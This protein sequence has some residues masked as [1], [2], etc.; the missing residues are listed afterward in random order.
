[1]R[2]LRSSLA[3]GVF[4]G[5]APL[6]A[7]AQTSGQPEFPQPVMVLSAGA[8]ADLS[9][10]LLQGGGK[11]P[12]VA[13]L[14]NALLLPGVGNFY[15]GNSGHG[16]RHLLLHVGG[17]GVV[18]VGAAA[19]SDEIL[20]GGTIDE[21]S[22]AVLY[23]GLGIVTVNW[24]WSIFSGISDANAAGGRSAS[25]GPRL[26]TLSVSSPTLQA[27]APAQA[28]RVGLEVVRIGF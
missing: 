14:L 20:T 4:F 5:L 3:M 19:A 2:Q 12:A 21:G 8:P 6:A 7:Q 22:V 11:S 26:R 27:L 18:V 15:A 28:R 23:V 1:M 24:V 10:V 17:I 9:S 16:L 13:A 25:L